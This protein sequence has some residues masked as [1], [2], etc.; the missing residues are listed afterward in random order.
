MSLCKRCPSCGT[1]NIKKVES[2]DTGLPKSN[3]LQF[4]CLNC[5]TLW[6]I[7]HPPVKCLK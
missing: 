4:M 2:N 3:Q 5:G 6:T 7:S 1:K